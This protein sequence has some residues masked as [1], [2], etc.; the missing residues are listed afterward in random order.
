M[1]TRNIDKFANL[2]NAERIYNKNHKECLFLKNGINLI[3][4]GEIII[5]ISSLEI[6]LRLIIVFQVYIFKNI[7][8]KKWLEYY[9]IIKTTKIK[10]T[11]KEITRILFNYKN[12]EIKKYRKNR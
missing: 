12:K 5:I 10:N 6:K 1:T 11:E 3:D 4:K 8:K 7:I 2:R 9:L